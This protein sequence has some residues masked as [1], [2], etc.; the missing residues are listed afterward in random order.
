VDVN[1]RAVALT[2]ANAASLGLANV[3]AVTPDE[4]PGDVRFRAIWSNPPIRIGKAALQEILGIWLPR[5]EPTG[6]A[7]LVVHKHLGSDSLASWLAAEGWSV[8]RA[9]SRKGYRILSVGHR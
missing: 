8:E 1:R 3:R 2:A 9:A 7:W 5:L 4:V 6:R